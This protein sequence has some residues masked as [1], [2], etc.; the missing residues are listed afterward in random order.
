M[1][2]NS[3]EPGEQPEEKDQ[4]RSDKDPLWPYIGDWQALQNGTAHSMLLKELI[5]S[6]IQPRIGQ[7]LPLEDPLARYKDIPLHA[8]FLYTSLDP[9][10]ESYILN[11][12]VTID[13]LARDKCD[14]YLSIRQ[15]HNPGETIDYL[16]NSLI[17]RTSGVQIGYH[18]LPGIFFWDHQWEGEFV[19]LRRSGNESEISPV[20]LR[21]FQEIR[22]DPTIAAVRRAKKLLRL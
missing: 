14:I 3:Y 18:D 6:G 5:E 22:E 9:S 17:L 19:P 7:T 16:E 2:N 8:R 1:H 11:H 10:I 15:F 20:L 21:V 4:A 12:Y 13:S